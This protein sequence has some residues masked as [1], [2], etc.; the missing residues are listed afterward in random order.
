MRPFEVI[1]FDEAVADIQNAIDYYGE[2]A[3]SFAQTCRWAYD[4][5]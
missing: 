1:L 2:N 5:S 3:H 4:I